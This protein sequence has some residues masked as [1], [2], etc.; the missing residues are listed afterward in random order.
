METLLQQ[1]ADCIL[2]VCNLAELPEKLEGAKVRL[3]VCFYNRL[4]AEGEGARSV[5]SISQTFLQEMPA[6][7]RLQLEPYVQAEVMGGV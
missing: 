7:V 3:A 6:D 1:A 5:G 2:N 4:G